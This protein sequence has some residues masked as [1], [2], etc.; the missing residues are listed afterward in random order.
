MVN[1]S[2]MLGNFAGFSVI[3]AQ[4]IIEATT[5]KNLF[6]Q[7]NAIALVTRP[8]PSPQAGTGVIVKTMSEGGIG[9]R[10]MISYQHLKG[11]HLV[12]IDCLYGVAELRDDHGV[13]VLTD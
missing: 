2:F 12:S 7:S 11:G 1:P 9:L 3:E 4:G 10:V 13:V 8:L 5:Q 6:F